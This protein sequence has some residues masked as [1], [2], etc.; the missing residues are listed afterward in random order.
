MQS[1]DLLYAAQG[2][3]LN[4]AC[5][6]DITSAVVTDNNSTVLQQ[7]AVTEDDSKTTRCIAMYANAVHACIVSM[8]DSPSTLSRGT[9]F[10]AGLP[11]TKLSAAQLQELCWDV[12]SQKQ[13]S[14]S[15]STT[16]YYNVPQYTTTCYASCQSA[17]PHKVLY[18]LHTSVCHKEED[19]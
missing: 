12:Q 15:S 4:T 14:G 18:R 16:M 8:Q 19:T 10:A 7:Q 11:A 1:A 3:R 9:G 13:R 6:L 5:S 17:C 2:C